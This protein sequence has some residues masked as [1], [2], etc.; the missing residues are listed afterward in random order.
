MLEDLNSVNMNEEEGEE[1]N[2]MCVGVH[3][4]PV[5]VFQLL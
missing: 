3:S 1:Q 2:C 4:L 5:D